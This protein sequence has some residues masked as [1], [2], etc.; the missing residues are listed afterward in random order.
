MSEQYSLSV[1]RAQTYQLIC[2]LVVP[3]K[4]TECT[5]KDFIDMAQGHYRPK[6]SAIVERFMF[7]TQ[8]QKDG[9]TF[10]DF[11]AELR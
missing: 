3:R 1:C 9:E 2:N 7:N 5:F 10:A 4:P 6:L 8:V 11:V